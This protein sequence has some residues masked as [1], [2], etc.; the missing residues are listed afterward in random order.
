MAQNFKSFA[1]TI[2]SGASQSSVIDTEGM[3]LGAIKMP[4][5]WTAAAITL[6]GCDTA[7]GTFLPIYKD[8]GT[9]YSLTVAVDTIVAVDGAAMALA[10]V[11]FIK[12]RSGVA[13]TPVNQGGDRSLVLLCK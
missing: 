12:L 7:D 9:E 4:A 11:R 3:T 13:A 2:A 1:T 10:P 6:M 5:A 8:D